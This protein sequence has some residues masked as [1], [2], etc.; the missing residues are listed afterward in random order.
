VERICNLE[1]VEGLKCE[2][3][4]LGA[5]LQLESENQGP[6]CKIC[7]NTWTTG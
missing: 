1:G 2:I 5:S 6:N 3:R 7:K 4:W